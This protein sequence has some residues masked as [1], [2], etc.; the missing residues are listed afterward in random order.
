MITKVAGKPVENSSELANLIA[1]FK[2]GEEVPL[3]IHRK[4]DTREI[5]VKL[6]ERPL[7]DVAG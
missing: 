7:G 5:K 4:G 6:G 2:P 1:N 3:E